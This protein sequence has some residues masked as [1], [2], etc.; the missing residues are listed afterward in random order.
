MVQSRFQG[1]DQ[2]RLGWDSQAKNLYHSQLPGTN[3]TGG[4]VGTY[5]TFEL[6]CHISIPASLMQ[7]QGSGC[8]DNELKDVVHGG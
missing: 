4:L 1:T 5:C 7:G 8:L 2:G 3:T 6:Q